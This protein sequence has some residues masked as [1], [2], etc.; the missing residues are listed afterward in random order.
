M[1]RSGGELARRTAA[2][3]EEE[4]RAGIEEQEKAREDRCAAA[5]ARPTVPRGSPADAFAFLRSSIER[6]DTRRNNV[7]VQTQVLIF[8]C[9]VHN[10]IIFH[11]SLMLCKNKILYTWRIEMSKSM[12]FA[13]EISNQYESHNVDSVGWE[14][15]FSVQ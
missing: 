13:I 1:A 14:S 6:S 4:T 15:H 9:S 2:H 11:V 10:V 8:V 7:K 3:A 12:S 5:A